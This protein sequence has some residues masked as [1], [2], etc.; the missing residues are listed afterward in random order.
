MRT[1]FHYR[2]LAVAALLL[3]FALALNTAGQEAITT[4][5]PLHLAR[6]IAMRQIGYLSLSDKHVPLIYRLVSLAL[7]TEDDLP[8]MSHFAAWGAGSPYAIGQELVTTTGWPIDRAIWLSRA[9]IVLLGV[10]LGALLAAWTR[11]LTHHLP[12][13]AVVLGLYAL[14]PNLLAAASL[15]T[16]DMATTATTFAA[17]FTWW[18]YWRR[19]RAAWPDQRSGRSTPRRRRR[20]RS[21]PP[22]RGWDPCCR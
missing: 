3:F 18:R 6:G 4:D 13:T 12:A 9:V 14:S 7:L 19:P 17:V 8:Q 21:S 22:A 1:R 20:R 15:L 10:V 2:L 5:E 11:A 16:T